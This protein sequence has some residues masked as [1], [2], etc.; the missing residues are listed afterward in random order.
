MS[1][2]NAQSIF[3]V[4]LMQIWS[5]FWKIWWLA[6]HGVMLW[7]I[8]HSAPVDRVWF[9]RTLTSNILYI[10]S[11]CMGKRVCVTLWWL[12]GRFRIKPDV[13]MY[14][15][16]TWTGI[17]SFSWTKLLGLDGV[18]SSWKLSSVAMISCT[19]LVSSFISCQTWMRQHEH[20][21]AIQIK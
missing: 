14:L 4:F 7:S 5:K 20:T 11:Y 12:L 16:S 19:C 21:K 17:M 8:T 15:C 1:L 13:D 10:I 9:G 6:I 2:L 18:D 3:Q